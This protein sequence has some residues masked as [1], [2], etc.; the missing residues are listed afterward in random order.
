MSRAYNCTVRDVK[1][2]RETGIKFYKELDMIGIHAVGA[3]LCVPAHVIC[4]LGHV[5][6][7]CDLCP[8]HVMCDLR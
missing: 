3:F 5:T 4:D 1:E 2:T 6:W 8:A 7:S